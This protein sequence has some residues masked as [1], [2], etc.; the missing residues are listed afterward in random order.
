[1]TTI[2]PPVTSEALA[3]TQFLRTSALYFGL[4]TPAREQRVA[5]LP[6]LGRRPPSTTSP[7]PARVW[8]PGQS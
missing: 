6:A 4:T 2:L 7:A 3:V 1:M 8:V 5:P